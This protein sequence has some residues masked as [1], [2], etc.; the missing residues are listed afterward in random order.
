[1]NYGEELAYWYLRLNGFFP[2]S[3]FVVHRSLDVPNTSDVDV[4]AVRPPHVFEQ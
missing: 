2:I 1:M 3:N 4:V